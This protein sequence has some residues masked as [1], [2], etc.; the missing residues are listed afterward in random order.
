MMPS[1]RVF[2]NNFYLKVSK[3]HESVNTPFFG[4]ESSQKSAA[5]GHH[6]HDGEEDRG[7]DA[8]R[9]GH[10]GRVQ[11]LLDVGGLRQPLDV[12]VHLRVHPWEPGPRA[13]RPEADNPDKLSVTDKRSSAV[14]LT[15]VN[16][17]LSIK[18]LYN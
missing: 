2:G 8:E 10:G 13:P 6:E 5:E 3:N 18:Y 7:D 15:T 16:T 1:T 11:V 4:F 17:S 14:P 9:G 12:P